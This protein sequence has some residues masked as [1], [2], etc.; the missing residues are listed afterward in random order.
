M[1]YYYQFLD[2]DAFDQLLRLSW[3]EFL[4]KWGR[5]PWAKGAATGDAYGSLREFIAFSLSP[6][7]SPEEVEAILSLKT[8]RWTIQRSLPQLAAMAGL[9]DCVSAFRRHAVCVGFF[10]HSEFAVL[11]AAAVEAYLG[12]RIPRTMILPLFDLHRVADLSPWL[13]LSRSERRILR[14]DVSLPEICRPIYKWQG[15]DFLHDEEWANCLSV[16]DTRQVIACLM[17][18]WRENWPVSLMKDL[19]DTSAPAEIRGSPRFRDFDISRQF[20]KALRSRL[21]NLERPVVFFRCD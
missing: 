20:A 3:R 17:Q 11:L 9:I 14:A 12:G 16:T 18:A 7:P 1:E 10:K 19:S 15:A 8:I 2:R 6:E 21:P 5:T 13:R 4:Q